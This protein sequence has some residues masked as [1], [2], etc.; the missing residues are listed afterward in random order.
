MPIYEFE[1]RACGHGF[2]ALRPLGD[3]GAS[4]TCPKCEAPS[5]SKKLS[6][7]AAGSSPDR[8]TPPCGSGACGPGAGSGFG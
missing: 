5:P 7:F 1:C 6:V 3:T 4:L 2:E 8:T